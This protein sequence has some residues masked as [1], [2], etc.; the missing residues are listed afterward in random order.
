MGQVRE[1]VIVT[2]CREALW[3][4]AGCQR[5]K[6]T[7][8]A[9]TTEFEELTMQESGHSLKYGEWGSSLFYGG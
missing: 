3:W 7:M 6:L 1:S 8:A 5:T 4:N 9:P 2:P